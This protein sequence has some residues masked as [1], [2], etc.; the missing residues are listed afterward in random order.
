[1]VQGA[2]GGR[3]LHL[4][5][6]Q[7]A[8]AGRRVVRVL[9]WAGS[10][11]ATTFLR[12]RVRT[13]TVLCAAVTERA[14]ATVRAVTRLAWAVRGMGFAPDLATALAAGFGAALRA[15]GLAA[16]RVVVLAA[17]R[18]DGFAATLRADGFAAALRADGFAA[19][20]RVDDVPAT[21]RV[22]GFAA[23]LRVDGFA[24]TLRVDG[25]ATTLR[26]GDVPATLRADGFAT[27]LR[28]AVPA[29]LRADGFATTL[30]AAVPATLRADG[31]A[32]TLR[33][34]VPAALR[35]DGLAT[36]LRVGDVPATLRADGFATTLRAAVPAALRVD[37]LATALRV[38]DV[39]TA[40]RVDDAADRADGFATARVVLRP[41]GR[42]TVRLVDLTADWV[43]N[44]AAALVAC[45]AGRGAL[46]G[47]VADRDAA[48]VDCLAVRVA[49]LAT[50]ALL[51]AGFAVMAPVFRLLR[52]V[53]A[54]R[55]VVAVAVFT[56][57]V[58]AVVG[59]SG[60]ASV[61]ERRVA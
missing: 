7:R 15:V 21:L 50:E 38:D 53:G 51:A 35:V 5:S 9:R 57:F 42:A 32:T 24:T 26:A 36:A 46:A 8:T 48:L 40:L 2:T 54:V 34:A 49:G 23:T 17:G 4:K 27:T 19:T 25:F 28:A 41:A 30:R 6:G 39:P 13:A 60:V 45:L 44:V 43:N 22:D 47:R 31:L 58:L 18:A 1:M 61:G 33:A 3:P 55:F 12:V 10:F 56:G 20:L 11:G 52:A 16:M 59:R 37:G 29:A 14:C